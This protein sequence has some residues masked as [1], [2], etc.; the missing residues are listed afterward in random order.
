M[1]ILQDPAIISRLLR[2]FIHIWPWVST[3]NEMLHQFMKLL[4]TICEDSLP[5]K[6]RCVF[7]F[8]SSFISF[9]FLVCKAMTAVVVG[10]SQSMLQLVATYC[11]KESVKVKY[12]QSNLDVLDLALLVLSNCC[13]CFEGRNQIYKVSSIQ[14]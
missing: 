2:V 10:N 9:R 11:T 14:E 5:G 6:F 12:Q 8:N 13:A 4:A 3:S 7:S 1:E